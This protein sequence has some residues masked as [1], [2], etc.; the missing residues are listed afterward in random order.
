MNA[1]KVSPPA[2]E[3]FNTDNFFIFVKNDQSLWWDKTTGLFYSKPG[4]FFPFN[5]LT[6]WFGFN[7]SW[8]IACLVTAPMHGNMLWDYWESPIAQCLGNQSSCY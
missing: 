1:E 8:G 7:F 6:R 3:V 2:I 5:N 4:N